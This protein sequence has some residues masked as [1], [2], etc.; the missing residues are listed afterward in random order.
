M[1]E[2]DSPRRRRK[3]SAIM[4]ADVSGFSRLMGADEEDTVNLIQ[5][6]HSRVRKLVEAHEGR[7]VDTAGDSVFG[8]FDSVVN[9]LDCARRIQE[10]QSEINVAQPGERQIELRIGVHL[11]DVIVED[12]HVYGDGVN[13]AARLENL[14][15]PGGIAISG[16][17]Y[18]QVQHKLDMPIRDLGLQE[19]KNIQFPI[20]VYEVRP[21]PEA[22][23]TEDPRPGSPPADESPIRSAI[24]ENDDSEVRSW[25]SAILCRSVLIP[26][27]I[28]MFLFFSPLIL[29]PSGGALTTLGAI[30]LGLTGGRVVGRA[31]NTRGAVRYGM[32]AA[33]ASGALWTNWSSVTN[34][35]FVLGGLI[36]AATALQ[37]QG[38]KKAEHRREKQ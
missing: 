8:E 12:Y 5:D 38:G 14:A 23:T 37:R 1:T 28:G 2:L 33:I 21:A 24:A 30:V 3:L 4:M 16:A 27:L 31:T 11:G 7:V 20:H 10:Q 13:I 17:V 18:Q 34:S 32:G 26:A 19:L 35:L 22:A 36:V 9:A 15:V 29:F 25:R 6:F